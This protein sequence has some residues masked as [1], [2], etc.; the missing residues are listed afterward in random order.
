MM[1]FLSITVMFFLLIE[2]VTSSHSTTT[3]RIAVLLPTDP[4]L[5]YAMQK[6]KPAINLAVDEVIEKHLK[7]V[8]V[9]RIH[10]ILL[11]LY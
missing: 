11:D 5:P 9:I 8:M 10:R 6:V 1:W 4:A 3:V 2:H 7:F